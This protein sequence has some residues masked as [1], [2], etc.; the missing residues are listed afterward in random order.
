MEEYD[1]KIRKLKE[2]LAII[3]EQ[4]LLK[5]E[6]ERIKK[7]EELEK[8]KIEEENKRKIEE[9]KI[10]VDQEKNRIREEIKKSLFYK[11][12][13][14][15]FIH[16]EL[17][18]KI[19]KIDFTI[20]KNDILKKL[21]K[22]NII[23]IE[24]LDYNTKKYTIFIS[25]NGDGYYKEMNSLEFKW[26]DEVEEELLIFGCINKN[27]INNVFSNVQDILKPIFP[28]LENRLN[29]KFGNIEKIYTLYL[30]EEEIKK[31]KELEKI[32]EKIRL[33]EELKH[34]AKIREEEIRKLEE[35]EKRLE[36][37][38]EDI[39]REEKIRRENEKNRIE[40][41]RI[42]RL[43]RQQEYIS[44]NNNNNYQQIEED[45]DRLKHEKISNLIN[46]AQ[47]TNNYAGF[48]SHGITYGDIREYFG[49]SAEP[50]VDQIINRFKNSLR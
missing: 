28:I 29:F 34:K 40:K 49:T 27:L 38:Q 1:E 26:F 24:F 43:Q 6:E 15:P 35:E 44:Q 25:I 22:Y 18:T 9:E 2:E 16:E 23:H 48:N 37:I 12:S 10:K 46:Q 19:Y 4:K 3:E 33:E 39:F 17:L 11:D 30:K 47:I 31:Q 42:Y 13:Y 45:K 8:I 41:E 14:L 50:G 7:E 21:Q 36:K 32:Q 20:N 5:I